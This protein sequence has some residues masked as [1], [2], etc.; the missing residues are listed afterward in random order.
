MIKQNNKRTSIIMSIVALLL[1]LTLAAGFTFSWAEGGS[2]GKVDGNSLVINSGSDLVMRQDDKVVSDI[3]IP[4]TN[5][6][7][8][9]SADGRN[10]FVPMEYNT[11][12]DTNEMFFREGAPIDVNKKYV[13]IDFQLQA[14]ED[15]TPVY[16]GAGTGVTCSD[17]SVLE[18][19]RMSFSLNDAVNDAKIENDVITVN[20]DPLVFKPNQMPGVDEDIPFTPITSITDAGIAT[21][22]ETYSLAY[23]DYYFKG[24]GKSTPIFKLAEG[25]TKNIT[26]TIW[27]EGTVAT[28]SNAGKNLDIYIDF[29]TTTSDLTKYNFIDNTHG[30]NGAKA[31]YWVSEKADNDQYETMMYIYDTDTSRYYAMNKS[32]DYSSD[33]TWFG[34]VPSTISNFTFRRYSITINKYWNQW[35]PDMG[36]AIVKDPKG[37]YSYVAICGNTLD[38]EYQ[39]DGCYGYW[40]NE[41]DTIRVYLKEKYGVWDEK[42]LLCHAYRTTDDATTTGWYT[43]NM[44]WVKNTD[45]EKKEDLWYCDINYGSELTGIKFSPN[46]DPKSDTNTYIFF[47]NETQYYFNG[48]ATWYETNESNGKKNDSHWIYTDSENSLIHPDYDPTT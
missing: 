47:S 17:Q 1:I 12:V 11:S 20:E 46:I 24:E 18:A 25:E 3:I 27:L 2:R 5:L 4:V 48:F 37:E 35:E 45:N 21:T 30:Y 41:Y 13:S 33:H 43:Y 44:V 38:Y 16:L 31:E 32:T 29:T 22:T 36:S 7:P 15:I 14:G 34:Y 10:F 9:S 42:D 26:L 19:L 28:E 40:K 6:E 8:V 39:N 23:G